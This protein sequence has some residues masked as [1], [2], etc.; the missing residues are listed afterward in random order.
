MMIYTSIKKSN[1]KKDISKPF[2]LR[3]VETNTRNCSGISGR[4]RKV[5]ATGPR[6]YDFIVCLGHDHWMTYYSRNADV[7][8][9]PT[10]MLKSIRHAPSIF[11]NVMIIYV[12]HLL[13]FYSDQCY[14][15]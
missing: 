1:K 7:R 13:F 3:F 14:P 4:T 5:S 10:N 2:E 9:S 8:H 15:D 6:S 12:Y 11:I